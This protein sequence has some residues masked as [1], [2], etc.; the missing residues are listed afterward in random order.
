PGRG[1]IGLV[2]SIN[3]AAL[4]TSSFSHDAIVIGGSD[5]AG[6]VAAVDAFIEILKVKDVEVGGEAG[7][8]VLKPAPPAS[9]VNA[10]PVAAERE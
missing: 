7:T 5:D 4:D 2:E 10:D 6:T 3:R 1:A 8:E 9:V